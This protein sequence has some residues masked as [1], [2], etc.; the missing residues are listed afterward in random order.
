MAAGDLR[1]KIDE[2]KLTADLKAWGAGLDASRATVTGTGKGQVLT[3]RRKKI[4]G[5]KRQPLHGRGVANILADRGH[6]VFRYSNAVADRVESLIASESTDAIVDAYRTGQ[7]QTERIR[8]ALRLA[9]MELAEDAR[10]YISSGDLGQ[11]KVRRTKRS[12]W[13]NY[14]AR[15][16]RLGRASL[17][18][19]NPPPLG[20]LTGRFL[21]GIRG[22]FTM[23]R[24]VF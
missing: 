7:P 19:G 10:H 22:F 18:F 4:A 12:A 3:S 8:S 16:A 11:K 5:E 21:E 23:G 13:K 9:A 20:Y 17:R 24:S 2:R 15:L 14:W 1:L 6:D